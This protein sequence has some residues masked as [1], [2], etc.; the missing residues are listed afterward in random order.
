MATASLLAFYRAGVE[1][2][3]AATVVLTTNL[4]TLTG[5]KHGTSPK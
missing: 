3:G 2:P 4:S 5:D 1:G